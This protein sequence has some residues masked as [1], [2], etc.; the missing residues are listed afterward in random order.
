MPDVFDG[1]TFGVYENN[2]GQGRGGE[3]GRHFSRNLL[4]MLLAIYHMRFPF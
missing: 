3:G 2:M 1:G 4:H